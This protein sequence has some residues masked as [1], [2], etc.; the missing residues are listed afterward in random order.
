[1][2]KTADVVIIGGGIIGL[3]TAFQLARHNYGK[4][5]VLEKDLFLGTGATAK[6]AGGIR[7]QF[8]TRINIE[9]SMKSEEMLAN[10]EKENDYPVVFEQNGY[11]FLIFDDRQL[12]E[13]TKS[14][15]LQRSLGLKVEWLDIP[16]INE[17]APPVRTDDVIKATFCH[18]DGIAD[19]S[20]MINGYSTVARR[21]GV[22]IEFETEVTGFNIEAGEIKSVITTKGDISTPLVI[23]A[24]GPYAGVIGKMAGAEV[25]VQPVRRQIVTTGPLDY[26]PHTFPMVVDVNSG[27][28]FHK[29]SPGLLLGWADPEVKPGFDE[30]VDPDYNDMIIMKALERVPRLET[31][32]MAKSWAGLYETT[33]DHH[34]II[35]FTEEVKGFFVCSGFSGHGLMHAP[36]AG[37]VAAEKIC[38]KKT[39]IDI[40]PLSLKRFAHGALT[41]ETNVI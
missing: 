18:D 15:E 35:D 7:A 40:S 33:P 6:C 27:L 39:T 10:F 1:M 21:L 12:A 25:P 24:A 23:N 32:E 17:I 2:N 3:S 22:N 9:M 13:F 30:S 5:V 34:A 36:A 37:L 16:R 4:I 41:E 28:Y 29:E 19:P 11:M 8:T 31:A 38:G 14:V 20:D 26:I